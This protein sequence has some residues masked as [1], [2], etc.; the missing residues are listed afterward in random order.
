MDNGM[1][2]LFS[3]S[4]YTAVH[5]QLNDS[6]P[7]KANSFLK[8]KSKSKLTDIQKKDHVGAKSWRDGMTLMKRPNKI[9]S[10]TT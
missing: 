5:V 4:Y 9:T 6:I 1:R 7:Q 3:P 2:P 8:V 10:T